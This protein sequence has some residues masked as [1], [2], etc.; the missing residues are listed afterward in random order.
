MRGRRFRHLRHVKRRL[1]NLL[2][3]L[4][5]L[6][7]A[8]VVALWVRS[9]FRVDIWVFVERADAR[10]LSLDYLVSDH[11]KFQ[12]RRSGGRP[13]PGYRRFEVDHRVEPASYGRDYRKVYDMGRASP[14]GVRTNFWFA[15]FGLFRYGYAA[16]WHADVVV[17][18]WLVALIFASLP[19]ARLYRRPRAKRPPGV[20]RACGY[21][22]RATPGRCPEC[23]TPAVSP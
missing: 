12:I 13:A 19:A 6:L 7:C 14:A 21:D 11:G 15:G 5:L 1:L 4:S 22:L 17:P 10:G 9:Y 3:V 23:G 8:A 16:G 20:C 2:T 18:Q